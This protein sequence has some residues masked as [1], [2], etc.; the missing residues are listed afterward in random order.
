[1]KLERRAAD[2]GRILGLTAAGVVAALACA[3]SACD[4]VQS[5]SG[6]AITT[7]PTTQTVTAC[8]GA[9]NTPYLPLNRI[10]ADVRGPPR[11]GTS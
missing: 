11:R 9:A 8:I 5:G 2:G 4:R 1:M 10:C 6:T 3:L 7:G